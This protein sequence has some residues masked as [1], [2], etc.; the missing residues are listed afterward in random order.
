MWS[1]D[2]SSTIL[3]PV[4]S[5]ALLQCRC[6]EVRGYVDGA[7]PDSTNRVVCYCADC[8]AFL[9]ALERPDLFADPQGGS[10]IVQVAPAAL[11]FEEGRDRI[12][13]MRLTPKG[14]LRF[15]ASC[16]KTPL[17]NTVGPVVPFVGILAPA[18][19]RDGLGA[20]EA[21]GPVRARI[22]GK[23]AIGAPPPGSERMQLGF[24]LRVLRLI[25]GWKLSGKTWPH[26]FF[27]RGEKLP[28]YPVEVLRAEEREALRA[29]TGPRPS[30]P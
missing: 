7:S 13:A 5:R 25:G 23:S 6:G 11:R 17:G 26:P 27:E 19:G 9:F 20:D 4:R 10:D 14:L 12:R 1:A 30:A 2:G 3:A 28:R 15:Y 22:L 21:F 18:F 8:Q 29:R 24:L 16:C